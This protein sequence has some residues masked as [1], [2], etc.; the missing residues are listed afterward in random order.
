MTY[1]GC[2][3]ALFDAATASQVQLLIRNLV[4]APTM[5]RFCGDG[6]AKQTAPYG[7][8]PRP[9]RTDGATAN[10]AAVGA[11]IKPGLTPDLLVLRSERY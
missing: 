9:S 7:Y 1:R 3:Q 11:A 5:G 4:D 10:P 8:P 2:G 6:G